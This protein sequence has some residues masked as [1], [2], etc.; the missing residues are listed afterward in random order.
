MSCVRE[1]RVAAFSQRR[2]AE[3]LRCWAPP[4]EPAAVAAAQAAAVAAVGHQGEPPWNTSAI[5]PKFSLFKWGPSSTITKRETDLL[6]YGLLG[7]HVGLLWGHIRV[8]SWQCWNHILHTVGL[9]SHVA[10]TVS[11]D[12]LGHGGH[13][14]GL[15]HHVLS[16]ENLSLNI[17]SINWSKKMMCQVRPDSPARV[18][19]GSW[20][21]MD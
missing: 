12:S 3:P 14:L 1:T 18:W 6:V 15:R 17:L 4:G 8:L 20:S 7:W 19:V 5:E 21:M 11:R 13:W 2:W 10:H 16:K 9:V